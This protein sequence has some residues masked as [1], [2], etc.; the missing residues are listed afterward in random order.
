MIRFGDTET[1]SA[2]NLIEILQ[3]CSANTGIPLDR[4]PVAIE[5]YRGEEQ[6]IVRYEVN[7]FWN[8]SAVYLIT[9]YD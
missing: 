8:N 6:Y 5:D 9:D 1:I 2:Q 7:N 3:A 4:L